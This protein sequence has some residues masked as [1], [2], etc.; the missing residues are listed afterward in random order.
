[1]FNPHNI[2]SRQQLMLTCCYQS[3]REHFSH[4]AIRDIIAPPHGMFDALLARQVA[5]TLMR[6]EFNVPRRRIATMLSRQRTRISFIM[7][8]VTFRRDCAVF[9]IA[10]QR[11]ASRAREIFNR[12]IRK[13]AA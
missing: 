1:M 8:T 5:I 12:E 3:V 11:M 13:A 2:D 6:D 10:Y 9:E 4:L 7:Q